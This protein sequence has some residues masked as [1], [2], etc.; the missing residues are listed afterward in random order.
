[1]TNYKYSCIDPKPAN[2]INNTIHGTIN[3]S[4]FVT[5]GIFWLCR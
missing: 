2:N 5:T 4:I 3:S 1:M